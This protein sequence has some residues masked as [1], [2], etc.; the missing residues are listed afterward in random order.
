[1]LVI[2][3]NEFATTALF[4][5]TLVNL[6]YLV[7]ALAPTHFTHSCFVGVILWPGYSCLREF[8]LT[9]IS[10]RS[11]KFPV[12]IVPPGTAVFSSAAGA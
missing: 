7:L 6:P 2:N 8:L 5:M 11:V 10:D 9:S 3:L 1:M 12:R 4:Y